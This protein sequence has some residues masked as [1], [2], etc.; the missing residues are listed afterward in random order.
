MSTLLSFYA[1]SSFCN[2][3]LELYSAPY[4]MGFAYLIVVAAGCFVVTK[5]HT[6]RGRVTVVGAEFGGQHVCASPTQHKQ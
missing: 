3:V 4:L 1:T 2:I 6:E 5:L